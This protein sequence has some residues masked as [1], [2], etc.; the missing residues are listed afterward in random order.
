MHAN[1]VHLTQEYAYVSIL[2]TATSLDVQ[3]GWPP[4]Y[5]EKYVVTIDLRVSLVFL[6]HHFS[7][8]FPSG[9]WFASVLGD[10]KH[11]VV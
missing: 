9:E 2:L 4:D 8:N 3:F 6:E 1:R 10:L 5:L 7:F 11:C